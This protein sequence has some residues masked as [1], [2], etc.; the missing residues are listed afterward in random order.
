MPPSNAAMGWASKLDCD[1]HYP[2]H[3]REHL[4]DL[5]LAA[6]ALHRER[7]VRSHC[8]RISPSSAA[9]ETDWQLSSGK[10]TSKLEGTRDRANRRRFQF[11]WCGNVIQLRVYNYYNSAINGKYFFLPYK[12]RLKMGPSLSIVAFG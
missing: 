11:S 6:P 3:P 2:E 10:W 9:R 5:P 1:R 7:R 12:N 4:R 8:W